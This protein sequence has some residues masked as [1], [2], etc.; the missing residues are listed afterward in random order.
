[1]RSTVL[2]IVLWTTAL[3]AA[4]DR[5]K[6]ANG[7][8]EGLGTQA[9]GVRAFKGVPFGQPPVGDLRWKSPQPVR[10]WTG[11]REA[12]QFGP[13]CMQLP[14]F[15]DM[16]FRSSGMGEDCLYLNV[17][18]PARSRQRS[19]AGAGLFLRRR[20]HRGRRLRAPLRR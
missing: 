11:V 12:K 17:W 6:T 15:G 1:M 19:A 5:V 3:A 14:V 2:A 16:N 20:L 18:T 8:I 10:N 13:R 9:N 7:T 4:P